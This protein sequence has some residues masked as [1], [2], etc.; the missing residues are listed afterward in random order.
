MSFGKV[1]GYK[2]NTYNQLHICTPGMSA[3]K[4]THYMYNINYPETRDN[5]IRVYTI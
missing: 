4:N 2:V 3:Y 1:A 5:A